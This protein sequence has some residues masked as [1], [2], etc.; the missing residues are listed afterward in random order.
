MKAMKMNLDYIK[1]WLKA[2]LDEERYIH[3]LASEKTAKELAIRFGADEEKASLSALLHDCAKCI[4]TEELYK[5]IEE[6]NLNVSK[7][8]LASYKTLHAPVGAYLAKQQFGIV[9]KEVLQSIRFHTIGRVGM[10]LIEKIVFLA[11]KIEPATRE[12]EYINKVKSALD[13][14][15]NIDDALLICYDSTIRRLLDR[16]LIINPQTIEVYNDLVVTLLK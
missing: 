13:K 15:N 6:N 8:E 7:I 3:V 11:D 10:S 4:E 1:N 9:D 5:L 12:K 14:N 16:Q 2:N